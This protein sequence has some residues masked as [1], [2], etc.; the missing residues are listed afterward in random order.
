[1]QGN[2][3]KWDCSFPKNLVKG[4]GVVFIYSVFYSSHK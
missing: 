4:G 2:S 3:N 1:M